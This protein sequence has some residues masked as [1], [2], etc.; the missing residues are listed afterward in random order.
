MLGIFSNIR[1][2]YGSL[3]LK[4]VQIQFGNTKSLISFS[5]VIIK[6]YKQLSADRLYCF[7]AFL[8]LIATY[9]IR[10]YRRFAESKTQKLTAS[11]SSTN[12]SEV[13]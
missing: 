10:F 3:D 12:G 13:S 7:T 4:I 5:V 9:Q 11:E 1:E 2:I 6:R 8:S